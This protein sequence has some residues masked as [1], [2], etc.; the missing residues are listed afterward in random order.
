[1]IEKSFTGPL[2]SFIRFILANM[3]TELPVACTSLAQQQS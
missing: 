2:V 3:P 1:M